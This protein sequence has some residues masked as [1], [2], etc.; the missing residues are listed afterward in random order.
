MSLFFICLLSVFSLFAEESLGSYLTSEHN[1]LALLEEV[2]NTQNG[3]L[4]QI[5]Q[6]I[7]VDGPSP[8]N[9]LRYYDAGHH[10]EGDFGYGI[11]LSLPLKLDF[12]AS[13]ASL[14]VQERVG[15]FLPFSTELKG[16]VY[17]GQVR[18]KMLKDGYSNCCEA[19][20]R[21]EPPI[22]AMRAEGSV[23]KMCVKL[24]DGTRRIYEMYRKRHN[25]HF[26]LVRE[27]FPNGNL[28]HYTYLADPPSRV[29][30]IWTTNG[31]QSLVLNWIN[32]TYDSDVI[33]LEASNQQ[34]VQYFKHKRLCKLREK[35]RAQR[36]DW[37][38]QGHL[39]S[40]TILDPSER[41]VRKKTYIYNTD[42]Y[43]TKASIRGVIQEVGVQSTYGVNYD[44]SCDDL[45]LL[46]KENHNGKVHY[47]YSYIPGTNLRATKE[48]KADGKTQ[49]R[50]F[51]Y[52]DKNGI[53][54][55]KIVDDGSQGSDQL[56]LTDVTYRKVTVI[57]P[58]LDPNQSYITQPKVIQEFYLDP[59]TKTRHLL[60]CFEREYSHGNLLT[61]ERVFDAN[62]AYCF[63]RKYVY[64]DKRQLLSETNA[65]GEITL[66]KYD[67]NGN[68]TSE[69]K[70][71]SEKK[72]LFEYD[73]ANRLI[74]EVETYTDGRTRVTKHAY[75]AMNNKIATVDTYGQITRYTYDAFGRRLSKDDATGT[76]HYLYQFDTEIG[77]YKNGLEEF[78]AIFG[79]HAPF[80]TELHGKTYF[81]LR[82]HR[83][84]ICVLLNSQ[85]QPV[86][87][88]RYD[89]YGIPSLQGAPTSPWLF[90]G[91]RYELGLYHYDKR[92]YDPHLGRWLTPDPLGFADGPNPYAYVHN[93]P[94]TFVDPYGL[95]TLGT[96]LITDMGF[97]NMVQS[98][99]LTNF[100]SGF[101]RGAVDDASWGL[102]NLVLGEHQPHSL[103]SR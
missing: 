1:T 93:C 55:L 14:D 29:K 48:V 96:P 15:S 64:N 46:Q 45:H 75:D 103:R 34:T 58:Y 18:S 10:F 54:T 24:G 67:L 51:Y 2:V 81:P 62:D 73:T 57:E 16:S 65:I 84:D 33:K 72:T 6:D 92:E 88:T 61:E 19:L 71:G 7:H 53:L 69:E 25:H 8:L 99:T 90:S 70:V 66:Y 35:H 77:T 12:E 21:G 74:R 26:R 4:V 30:R 98:P 3:K 36:F 82:N 78:R 27:E 39:L 47:Q 32:F 22:Y 56:D 76:L 80:A 97:F 23:N 91:Q 86:S 79:K 85:G 31:E 59:V 101:S 17:R 13:G 50:E 100:A 83:G 43:I 94:L 20:L 44:Y 60:K 52:H 63:S 87:T 40:H 11:G 102:S 68:K 89:A 95:L 38:D 42:G 28:R 37:S 9:I 5:N 49:E 41:E